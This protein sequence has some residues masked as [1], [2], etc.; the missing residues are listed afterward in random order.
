MAYLTNL[1]ARSSCANIAVVPRPG[2]K[3]GRGKGAMVF[4]SRQMFYFRLHDNA[5]MLGNSQKLYKIVSR[6]L[7]LE[8]N[9]KAKLVRVWFGVEVGYGWRYLRLKKAPH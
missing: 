4:R 6:M 1:P 2:L 9:S 5:V 3:A 8:G 7:T